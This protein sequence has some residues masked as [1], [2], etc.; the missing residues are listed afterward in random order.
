MNLNENSDSEEEFSGFPDESDVWSGFDG[1]VRS[2]SAGSMTN[3]NI[4][5]FCLFYS[6]LNAI[7]AVSADF[8]NV[9]WIPDGNESEAE[10]LDDEEGDE[11]DRLYSSLSVPDNI[12]VFDPQL[13]SDDGATDVEEDNP[14]KIE[15]VCGAPKSK[16]RKRQ[17]TGE[18][19]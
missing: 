1:G 3:V 12:E 19:S 13:D 14:S 4:V 5:F 11:V 17:A 7:L 9:V 10:E 6:I 2:R 18:G 8:V 15:D 16:K